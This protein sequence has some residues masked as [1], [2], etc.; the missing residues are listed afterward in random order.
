MTPIQVVAAIM[1]NDQQEILIT[2]RPLH[3]S[4]GGLW[5]FPGG[6]IEK[7]ES[8]EMALVREI[9]E[10]LNVTIKIEDFVHSC[11]HDYGSVV[12]ELFAYF[13][14]IMTGTIHLH[15]H[16]DMKWVSLD[17]L[18]RYDLAPADIPIAEKIKEFF[19]T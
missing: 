13:S 17:T 14:K 11:E 15:E 7:G 3:K 18:E 12:I 8:K 10:E 2:Q 5:E 16:I 4:Q 19:K 1:I 6:K 9:K